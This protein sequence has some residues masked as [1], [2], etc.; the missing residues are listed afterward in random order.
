MYELN[1]I[2]GKIDNIEEND[3]KP[4]I[5]TKQ[6]RIV[7]EK[8]VSDYLDDWRELYGSPFMWSVWF[9][10]AVIKHSLPH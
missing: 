10:Q 4:Y 6:Y 5:N 2:S 8:F 7:S 1:S 3:I 9:Q